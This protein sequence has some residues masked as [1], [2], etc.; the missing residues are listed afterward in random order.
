IAVL[1]K[2]DGL[3]DQ[4][5]T[6]AEIE[7]EVQRQVASVAETLHIDQARIFPVSAQK[8]LVAKVTHDDQLLR[9]S[10]LPELEAALIELLVPTK[11]DLVRNQTIAVVD[12]VVT[13]VRQTLAARE[14]NLVEQ[15]YELRAL[16]G[17]N[18]SSIERML[19]RAQS[20][21][22]EFEENVRKIFAARSV[23]TRLS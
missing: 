13:E 7:S 6:P 20:E 19:M 11:R 8:G 14:R 2:I 23:L 16:Q 21:Q 15:L 1:N 9:Q 10:R 5:K 18:Q 4:L 22:R 12:R 3:W 17:K